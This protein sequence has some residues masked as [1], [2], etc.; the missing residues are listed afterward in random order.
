MYKIKDLFDKVLGTTVLH[1]L[2]NKCLRR[3]VNSAK[4]GI[5]NQNK[6]NPHIRKRS[7]GSR[8]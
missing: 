3:D 2:I 5:V 6:S 7:Y 1:D 4:K 8:K